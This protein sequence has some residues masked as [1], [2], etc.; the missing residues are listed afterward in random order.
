MKNIETYICQWCNN[1]FDRKGY[2]W[3]VNKFCSHKCSYAYNTKQ[4][5]ILFDKRYQQWLNGQDI[6]VKKS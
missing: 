5:E 1:S 4:A 3:R 2:Q 6:G